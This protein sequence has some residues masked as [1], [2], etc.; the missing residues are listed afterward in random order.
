MK[1]RK[2]LLMNLFARQEL[3]CRLREQILD[4]VREGE[5]RMSR[6]GAFI[7]VYTTRCEIDS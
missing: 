1:S 4:T 5:G 6:E 2:L 3:K 7:Y